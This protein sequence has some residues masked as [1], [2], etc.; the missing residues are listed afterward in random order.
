MKDYYSFPGTFVWGVATAAYQVEGAADED[1]RGPSIWDTFSRMPGRVALDHTGDVAVDQYHRYKEDVQLMKSLGVRAYRF[2]V[3][4]PRVFPE[5]YGQV[6]EKGLAYYD[7]LVDELL[8]NGIEPWVTLFHW[9]LPQA[10]E[11]QFG[12]WESRETS[13]YFS[14]YAAAVSARL[15]DRVRHFFTINEFNNIA[16]GGHGGGVFA[17][18]KDLPPKQFNQVRHHAVL[19]HGLSVQ[20]IRDSARKPVVVGLAENPSIPVPVMETPEHIGA[21]RA[22]MRENNAHF[23]TAVMEGRYPGS[24]LEAQGDAA[25]EFT[26]ADMKAIGSPLDFVGINTYTPCYVR[27][28]AD[29]PGAFEIIPPPESYPHIMDL[30]WLRLGP[31]VLYWAPRLMKEVWGVDHVVIS[32]NGC[33]SSDR[34]AP[35]GEI[36]DT[37]RVMYIR[38]HLVHAH[39]AV[40]EGWPL[41]GYF[42]WSLLDN[43]EWARGYTCR[44]G[45]CYVNYRTLER[46]PKLSARYY[47]EVIA[48]SA[49]V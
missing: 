7:R 34:P 28:T 15:S 33:P 26:D 29:K 42:L 17:P 48:R 46:T 44:F 36:Y 27:A 12:G 1:G 49:V 41:K 23:L 19:A 30:G 43:F 16:D 25:P 37:D 10:L 39:R 18:G 32:E 40:S 2:S 38:N 13:K 24:Y 14:Q 45:I 4:W 3:S 6:N 47:R 9:D 35:D 22:A 8:A 31:E 20:A 5:G 11:D 21:A